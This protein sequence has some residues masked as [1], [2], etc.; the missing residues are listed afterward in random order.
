MET[1]RRVSVFLPAYN[2]VDNLERSVGD[3][4]WAADQVLTEY[5]VLIIDDGS[6]DGTAA[7]ADRLA[8]ENP[9]IRAAPTVGY[10]RK[11]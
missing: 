10:H 11:S 9:R 6:I 1:R 2:E 3:I 5:E 7:L 4:V 8:G